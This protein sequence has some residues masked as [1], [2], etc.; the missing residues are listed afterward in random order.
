MYIVDS[1]D[2][3]EYRR[4]QAREDLRRLL[5]EEQLRDVPLMVVANKQ[6]RFDDA[7]PIT[8]IAEHL[9]LHELRARKWSESGF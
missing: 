1:T 8:Y 3:D 9:K 4:Q 5:E 6:D 7:I 2:R